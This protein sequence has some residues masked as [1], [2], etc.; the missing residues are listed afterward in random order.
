MVASGTPATG[1]V[2]E[3][4]HEDGDR[5]VGRRPGTCLGVVGVDVGQAVLTGLVDGCHHLELDDQVPTRPCRS[6]CPG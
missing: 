2:G 3:S 6:L 1:L 4:R 5:G